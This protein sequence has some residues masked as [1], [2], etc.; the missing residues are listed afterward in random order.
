MISNVDVSAVLQ[1]LAGSLPVDQ[2]VWERDHVDVVHGELATAWQGSRHYC[3]M[4]ALAHSMHGMS[5]LEDA[6]GRIQR[7]AELMAS[8][9]RRV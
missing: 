4:T 3:S 2:L 5:K 7:A 8:Y 6:I 1:Q 9:A